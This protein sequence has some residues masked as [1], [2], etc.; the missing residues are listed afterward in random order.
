MIKYETY[1]TDHFCVAN[2]YRVFDGDHTGTKA[3]PAHMYWITGGPQTISK[4]TGGETVIT[5]PISTVKALLFRV[6]NSYTAFGSNIPASVPGSREPIPIKRTK[7]P[8]DEQFC[9][10]DGFYTQRKNIY[11]KRKGFLRSR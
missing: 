2:P 9:E 4:K 8:L 1:R 10:A 11:T 5:K 6:R 7:Y 3:V